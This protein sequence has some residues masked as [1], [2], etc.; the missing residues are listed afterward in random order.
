MSYFSQKKFQ[1]SSIFLSKIM[2]GFVP[3]K[4]S[5]YHVGPAPFIFTFGMVFSPMPTPIST[6]NDIGDFQYTIQVL[7]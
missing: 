7:E 2:L 1:D 5:T 6:I 4:G 3:C